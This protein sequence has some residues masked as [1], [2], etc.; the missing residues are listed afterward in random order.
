MQVLYNPAQ[1]QVRNYSSND[2]RYNCTH[3]VDVVE[4]E[5]ARGAGRGGMER[6]AAS[7]TELR[8]RHCSELLRV[9]HPI[10]E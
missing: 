7:Q 1:R 5:D 2:L 3:R 9:R 4:A 8:Q 6:P 10:I